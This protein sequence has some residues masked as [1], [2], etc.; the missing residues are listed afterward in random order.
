[1]KRVLPISLVILAAAATAGLSEAKLPPKFDYIIYVKGKYAGK[2]STT[3]S[4]TAETYVF[5]SHTTV[6]SGEQNMDL[7][8]TTEVDKETFLPVKFTYDGDLRKK[9]VGGETTIEG[10]EATII[11]DID[12]ANYTATRVS[13][14]S[15]L[16]LEDYVMSHEV[17]IARAYWASGEDPARFGLLSPSISNLTSMEISKGSELSFESETKEAYCIKLVVSIKGGSAF[18]S[19]Y[20]P[21]RGLPVY[22]AFPGTATEVFLDEFFDG[23]PVSR[24]REE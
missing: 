16:L 24:Y 3:V 11:T 5:E 23:K 20:D 6:M 1:M 13:K 12:D 2:C 21:E 10:R 14:Q 4:E 18:A 9:V 8:S 22:L 17:V 19:Y 15:I 7:E